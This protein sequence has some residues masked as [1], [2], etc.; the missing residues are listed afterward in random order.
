M[1]KQ[2][3]LN[4][5]FVKKLAT[6]HAHNWSTTAFFYREVHNVNVY[7][8]V[9]EVV[10]FISYTLTFFSFFKVNLAKLLKK[11]ENRV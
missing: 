1:I 4:T 9:L 10:T 11:R 3:G 6:S 2:G 5:P 8:L 7:D